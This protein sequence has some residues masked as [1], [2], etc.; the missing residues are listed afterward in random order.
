M[1]TYPVIEHRVGR[2][3]RWLR[4]NRIRLAL[5][6]AV[7]ETLLVVGN[8]LRWFSV[9]AIAG[10]VFA[11]HLVVGRRARYESVR[12]L[13]WAAAVSQTL[14]VLIPVLVVLV[15]TLVVVAVVAVAAAVL[16]AF[17]LGRR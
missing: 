16:A 15:G 9:L 3:G 13:S 8:Q 11:F 14:P 2:A 7:A 5:L 17:L 10:L 6:I 12:Q 4:A 1:A